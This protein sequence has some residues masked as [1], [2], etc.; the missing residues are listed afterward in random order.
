M[1]DAWLA[2]TRKLQRAEINGLLDDEWEKHYDGV[3]ADDI[4][5]ALSNGNA[6]VS[7]V[8]VLRSVTRSKMRNEM[9]D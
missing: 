5:Q 3:S 6:A 8:N 1:R 7:N 4:T 2:I 9:F